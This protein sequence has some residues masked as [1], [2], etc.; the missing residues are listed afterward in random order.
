MEP[1]SL[2]IALKAVA[3]VRKTLDAAA[4]RAR[5]ENLERQVTDIGRHLSD[6][7]IADLRAGFRHLETAATASDGAFRRDE[8]NHARGLFARLAERS[9]Q[10]P[11]VDRFG[12][13]SAEQ[14]VALSHFGNYHYF[15]LRD[16]REHALLEAYR[17]AERFPALGVRL[18][19]AALFS[20]DFRGDVPSIATRDEFQAVYNNDLASHRQERRRYGLEMAWRLPA[21]AGYVLGGLAASAVNPSMAARGMQA[22]VGILATSERGL[23]PQSS[24]P[25]ID[26][27]RA[28]AAQVEQRL[29]PVADEAR[30]RRLLLEERLGV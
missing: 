9:S 16:Q 23:L 28:A 3:E 20:R 19:P 8:L 1:T 10:D 25:D 2:G 4:L 24:A 27:Y 17:C 12:Q 13:I 7:V 5:L 11:L 29:A 6:V 18:L 21:A 26:Y 15:L 14:V 30:Q 22:A